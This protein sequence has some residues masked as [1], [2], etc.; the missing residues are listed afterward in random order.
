MWVIVAALCLAPL[1]GLRADTL[2]GKPVLIDGDSIVVAGKPVRLWGI[3]APEMA[4]R[5]GYLAKRYLRTVIEDGTV[6]CVDEGMRTPGE[7]MAKCFIGQVDLGEIMILSGHA[8]EWHQYSQ[9][10]YNRVSGEAPAR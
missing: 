5:E 1:A 9:G 3:D 8:R 7:I 6:R 2:E 4:T 10:F